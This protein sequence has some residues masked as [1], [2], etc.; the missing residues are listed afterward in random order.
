MYRKR[1]IAAI[2]AAAMFAGVAANA[3]VDAEP[4]PTD[5]PLGPPVVY[6]DPVGD[7]PGGPDLVACGV[8]EP[9]QSLVSF[10]LEFAEEQLL[11]YDLETWTT[12]ELMVGIATKPDAVFPDEVEYIL[13]VHG[14]TLETEVKTGSPLFDTNQPEGMEVFWGVVDAD[15]DGPALTLSVDKKLLGDPDVLYFRAGA[16]SEGQDEAGGYDACPDEDE[17]PGEYVL[18]G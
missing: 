14:A 2:T 16:A 1:V 10:R 7:V 8:S 11:S 3:A 9:W 5:P 6:D 4:E 13:G 15:V 17:G 12:D 18:Y